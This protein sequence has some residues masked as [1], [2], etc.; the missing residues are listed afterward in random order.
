LDNIDLPHDSGDIIR[1]RC[2]VKAIETKIKRLQRSSCEEINAGMDGDIS[3]DVKGHSLAEKL[4]CLQN[5]SY[6]MWL[7]LSYWKGKTEV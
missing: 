6:M 4:M 5:N 7:N 2:G 3:A 1:M